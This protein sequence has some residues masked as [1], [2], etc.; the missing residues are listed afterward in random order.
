MIGSHKC[1]GSF[2]VFF[3]LMSC[4]KWRILS[5]LWAASPEGTNEWPWPASPAPGHPLGLEPLPEVWGVLPPALPWAA[6]HPLRLL[7]SL[8]P[9]CSWQPG[10]LLHIFSGGV[11]V[12]CGA[13]SPACCLL[14]TAWLA[15]GSPSAPSSL[16]PTLHTEVCLEKP[17]PSKLLLS[18][19]ACLPLP[20][21]AWISGDKEWHNWAGVF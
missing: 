9:S 17:P 5:E 16:T 15:L 4:H 2:L 13:A 18:A 6:G 7:S 20:T 14:G 8:H 10:V 3:F 1:G 11:G 19:E 12:P 21:A